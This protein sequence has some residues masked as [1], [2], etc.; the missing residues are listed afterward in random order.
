MSMAHS[1]EVRVP[2]LDNEVA[3]L[4]LPLR[5]GAKTDGRQGK[6]LLR[7]V[8]ARVLPAAASR[9]KQGFD[10][11]I[12]A[13]LRGALREALTDYLSEPAIS[14]G[15]IFRPQAVTRLV[16]EHLEGAADHGEELW[17]LVAFEAWRRR[18]LRPPAS[19]A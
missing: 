11:P 5:G 17:L 15:G 13:W 6:A 12:S 3:D 16:T 8:T 10:V 19:P 18:A 4:V 2:F 9:P 14:S 1:L 7:R